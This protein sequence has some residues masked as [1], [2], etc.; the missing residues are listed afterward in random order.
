[1]S[2]AVA[3]SRAGDGAVARWRRR[4]RAALVVALLVL[5]VPVAM[6]G[7]LG[8]AA[9]MAVLGIAAGLLGTTQRGPRETPRLWFP[10]LIAFGLWAAASSLWSPYPIPGGWEAALSPPARILFGIVAF[11]LAGGAIL[12][13]ARRAPDRMFHL[14][15]GV[16]TLIVGL[17][18]FDLASGY[19]LSLLVDP[20]GDNLVNRLGDARKNVGRGL[21]IA[22]LLLVPAVV[23][24]WRTLPD[25]N[26][27]LL[28]GVLTAGVVVGAGLCGLW[29][30]PTA[31]IAAV[32]L[33]GVAWLA[34]RAGIVFAFAS[35]ALSIV[36]APLAGQALAALSPDDAA[37]LPFSWEHRVEGWRYVAS[38]IGEAPL[39]GHGFD[40]ARTMD[41]TATIRGYDMALISLHPHNMGL[42]LW[43]ETGVIGVG[44]AVLAVCALCS[45]ALD[46]VGG[47]RGR[48]VAVAG[49][50]A[51]TTTVSAISFG[52]WQ[53]WWWASV[54][55]A[56]ALL[57]VLLRE[58]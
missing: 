22:T 31:L 30:V 32:A 29:V 7:G 51:C 12:H 36:L 33:C 8:V 54:F 45:L 49:L 11:T 24:A 17:S 16:L 25:M 39:M 52:V 57:P 5:L 21:V 47:D 10:A 38:R 56:G 26:G 44:L 2:G 28:G 46:W 1:M 14:A 18:L 55:L 37:R 43:L 48:A 6:A 50:V 42:H 34:P 4:I 41:A 23:G 58:P 40:A 9:L 3:L 20:P 13:T 19:G 35:A 53:E 15:L 27:P